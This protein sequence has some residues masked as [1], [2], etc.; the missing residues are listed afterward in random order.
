MLSSLTHLF[1]YQGQAHHL[2]HALDRSFEM[3]LYY[4]PVTDF[5]RHIS[6]K[7]VKSYFL[8][9]QKQITLLIDYLHAE[10][11]ASTTYSSCKREEFGCPYSYQ[12]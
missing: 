3:R 4:N 11:P 2:K 8:L 1:P 12:P 5:S 10:F 6:H 9:A 7:A